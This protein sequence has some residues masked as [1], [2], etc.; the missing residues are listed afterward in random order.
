MKYIE[1]MRHLTSFEK[2][3][4]HSPEKERM[5]E[6]NLVNLNPEKDKCYKCKKRIK[7]QYSHTIREIPR[8]F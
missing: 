4:Y 3:A 6:S 7:P 2:F 5:K 8:L 1:N